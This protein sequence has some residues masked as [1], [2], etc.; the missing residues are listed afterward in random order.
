MN[1]PNYGSK[2][3]IVPL[4]L[5]S[6]K[7]FWIVFCHILEHIFKMTMVSLK[8]YSPRRAKSTKI[9][10][11]MAQNEH[12]FWEKIMRA[13]HMMIK[14]Q[15]TNVILSPDWI[16]FMFYFMFYFCHSRCYT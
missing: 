9:D 15:I 7:F 2:I 12:F 5:I 16:P 14:I 1:N 11:K 4:K 8:E 6:P 10:R 13:A 3:K